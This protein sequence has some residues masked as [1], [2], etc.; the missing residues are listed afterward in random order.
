MESIFN[1]IST[2]FP[3]I[4]LLLL[5]IS[6]ILLVVFFV[7]IARLKKTAQKYKA[8]VEGME[9]KNLEEII[10]ENG[11]KLQQVLFEM[12]IF[13]DR[14]EVVEE[15]GEKSIQKVGLLRFDAFDDTGGELSYALALL[16]KANN[17]IVVSSIFGRDDARTYCKYVSGGKSKHPLSAEEQKAIRNALGLVD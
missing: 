16:N 10:L 1:W 15:I 8:L 5:A 17:G 2:N 6:L 3:L 13:R 7:T 14:L 11:K 4:I 12:N 9:G